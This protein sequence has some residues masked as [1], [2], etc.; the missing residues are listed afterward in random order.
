MRLR[1]ISQTI[2]E[3][4]TPWMGPLRNEFGNGE[5]YTLNYGTGDPSRP[6]FLYIPI[7]LDI[8]RSAKRK[9]IKKIGRPLTH[10]GE[11]H[12]TVSIGQELSDVLGDNPKQ[13]LI[14]AGLFDSGGNGISTPV[15]HTGEFKILNAP[16]YKDDADPEG[17]SLVAEVVEVPILKQIRELLGLSPEPAY[18]WL[19]GPYIPHI[20][21]GYMANLNKIH[22][23]YID[24]DS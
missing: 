7:P 16:F 17:P 23:S 14:N 15:Q 11:A 3:A 18:P 4:T 1:Q 24:K 9:L 10:V 13:V 20:T 12:V 2:L 22:Q 21:I 5:P 6:S 8:V 19:K